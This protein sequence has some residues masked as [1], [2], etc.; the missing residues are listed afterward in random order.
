MNLL[1]LFNSTIF[2][3]LAALHIY[4]AFGGKWAS[5]SVIPT[6]PDGKLTFQPPVL[7][8]LFV[9]AGLIVFATLTLLASTFFEGYMVSKYAK[10]GNYFIASLF[11]LR[12]IGDFKFVGF[13]KKITHTKFAI[14]DSKLYTPLSCLIGFNSFLIGFLST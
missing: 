5:D 1:I 11:T 7:T 6:F 10:S 14:N 8:T 4:W 2:I 12:S 13:S 3:F 9:T